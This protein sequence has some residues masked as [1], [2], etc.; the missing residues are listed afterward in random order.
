M[1]K[2]LY[3][4]TCILVLASCEDFLDTE[5]YVKKNTGNWPVT[6]DDATELLN[7]VYATLSDV[8]TNAADSYFYLA[9]LASDEHFG[10]GGENDKDMQGFDKLMNTKN[11]RML[12]FWEGRY[13]GIYRANMGIE[14]QENWLE[15]STASTHNRIIG[16][17]HFLR[18]FF[19]HELVEAFENIPLVLSTEPENLPQADPDLVYGQIAYDLKT[20]IELMSGTAPH[21]TCFQMGCRSIDGTCIPV[22][23]RFLQPDL[24]AFG[25][26]GR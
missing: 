1:K 12:T 3:L 15:A 26:W 22:L 19:Y 11:D 4:I 10:G 6:E 23:Y 14:T 8:S 18:G 13:K 24:F 17:I 9:E 25:K 21:G 20:A 5:N 2:L 16:E 7:S